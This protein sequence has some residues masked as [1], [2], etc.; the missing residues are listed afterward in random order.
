MK[1]F[2]E[3]LKNNHSLI[4]LHIL[5]NECQ[6]DMDG[7]TWPKPEIKKEERHK[8]LHSQSGNLERTSGVIGLV[9][10][11]FVRKCW[12]CEGWVPQTVSI[13]D[14]TEPV[15][16]HFEFD[17]WRPWHLQEG[18][19]TLNFMAPPGRWKFFF[20]S[21]LAKATVSLEHGIAV[22]PKPLNYNIVYDPKRDDMTTCEF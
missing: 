18:G 21:G 8:L 7:Y 15:F 1:S 10:Q 11:K 4:G 17:E 12:I 6:L 13:K 2:D 5:G 16:V 14:Q 20:T 3:F 22:R 9:N 19:T